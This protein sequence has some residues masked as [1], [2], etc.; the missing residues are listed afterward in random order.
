MSE[1]RK[2]HNQRRGGARRRAASSR[3]FWGS[4]PQDEDLDEL[5][6]RPVDDPTVMIR[7]LGPPPL[8]GGEMMA[9]HYFAAVYEKAAALALALAAASDLLD[10]GDD[11]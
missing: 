8:P 11:D 2:R 10:A 6:I 3:S 1:P 4:A 7:S 9:E 5:V